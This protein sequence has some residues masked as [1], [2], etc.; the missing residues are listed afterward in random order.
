MDPPAPGSRVGIVKELGGSRDE[1]RV[2][3]IT[4]AG[5]GLGGALVRGF[6]HAGWRVAAAG[7][8][9]LA[10]GRSEEEA[11]FP[12]VLDVT[13]RS[14]CES[15]VSTLEQRWG[16]VDMLIHT[17]GV[18]ADR[19]LA[20]MRESDWDS[21]VDV[22]LKGAFLC[23]QAVLPCMIRQGEGQIL[24]IGSFS[25]RAGAAG[26]VNY[27]AAKAGMIGLSM[28]L[29]REVADWGIR[30]N[31]VLPGVLPT[32]MTEGMTEVSREA[33][34]GANLLKRMNSP[35]EVASLAVALADARDVSGQVF[36]WDSR[37][38]RWA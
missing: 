24:N 37:I 8:R 11:I 7:H 30:V 28:S 25:G 31:V 12:C 20:T 19:L 16:R 4:G 6:V 29:A 14:Q 33:L 9:H 1:R 5:G 27:A 36:Q 26:Q 10:E 3:L 18:T 17:A 38:G 23:S 15:L 13:Q 22:H 2:I 21:V 34:V 35:Q 32:R